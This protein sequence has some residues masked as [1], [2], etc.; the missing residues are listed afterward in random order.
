MTE[1]SADVYNSKAVD[2]EGAM[3]Y[4]NDSTVRPFSFPGDFAENAEYITAAESGNVIE[5]FLKWLIDR[6]NEQVQEFQRFKLGNVTVSD[7]NN[8]LSRSSTEYAS[9]WETLKGKL[10]ES[11]LGGFLC[12]R[13]E[14]DGNY[15]DYLS[16]FTLTNTQEIVFGENLRDLKSH[17][18]LQYLH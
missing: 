9:T 11:A 18:R 2:L 7:P 10:F 15:I 1:D 6:H 5:F 14:S 8:Y 13:Y 12:I 16:E 4:F 17:C 3:A